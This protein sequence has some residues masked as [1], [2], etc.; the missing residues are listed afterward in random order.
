MPDAIE[1]AVANAMSRAF[2]EYTGT[3]EGQNMWNLDMEATWR[4]VAPAATATANA[5]S[6]SAWFE[7][8]RAA[9]ARDLDA[10]AWRRAAT[11]IEKGELPT[12]ISVEAV[13]RACAAAIKAAEKWAAA[14]PIPA[15]NLAKGNKAQHLARNW[16]RVVGPATATAV[17]AALTGD[18]DFEPGGQTGITI[19]FEHEQAGH[20]PE[21][22]GPCI[23]TVITW[24]DGTT[25]TGPWEPA[26]IYPETESTP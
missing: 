24:P 18:E 7:E 21:D 22:H 12:R 13:N 5:A 1:T 4:L 10:E 20:G 23:R 6:R 2:R 17:L 15:W 14:Y 11:L 3:P 26:D 16:A 9:A 25:L 19:T 8:G